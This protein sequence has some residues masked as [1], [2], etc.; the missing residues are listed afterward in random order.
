MD[1]LRLT[2]TGERDVAEWMQTASRADRERMAEFLE[3]LQD[4]TWQSRWWY[5]KFPPEPDAFEVRPDDGLYVYIRLMVDEEH[6]D[7]CVEFIKIYRDSS[8]K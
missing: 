8:M 3:T 2:T 7:M 1:R 5:A 6:G 4:G